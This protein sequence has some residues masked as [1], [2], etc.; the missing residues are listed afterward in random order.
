M[1]PE[2]SKFQDTDRCVRLEKS[3]GDRNLL[4]ED[5]FQTEDGASLILQ[6]WC[7]HL[8]LNLEIMH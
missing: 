3:T 5:E 8:R 1:D 7:L 4:L 6:F 2:T